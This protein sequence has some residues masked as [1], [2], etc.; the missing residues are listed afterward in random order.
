[1]V[2]LAVLHYLYLPLSSISK[3]GLLNRRSDFL[4]GEEEPVLPSDQPFREAGKVTGGVLSFSGALRRGLAKSALGDVPTGQAGAAL[5][6][7]G[8]DFGSKKI[9]AN[10]RKYDPDAKAPLSLRALQGA[11]NIATVWQPEHGP[12]VEITI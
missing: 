3:W 6:D 9:L 7:T 1:M 5:V 10:L 12:R 4:L 11:E 2:L 8:A